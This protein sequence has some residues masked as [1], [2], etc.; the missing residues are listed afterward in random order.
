MDTWTI[1]NKGMRGVSKTHKGGGGA[2]DKL[3]GWGGGRGRS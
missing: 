2:K 3:K 1:C